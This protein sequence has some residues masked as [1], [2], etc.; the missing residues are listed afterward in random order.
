[1]EELKTGLFPCDLSGRHST[2]PPISV[3][4]TISVIVFAP[5]ANKISSNRVT[6]II[7][8]WL[9]MAI[10]DED[11]YGSLLPSN[12]RGEPAG[13][14]TISALWLDPRIGLLSGSELVIQER[15][16]IEIINMLLLTIVAT[17][18]VAKLDR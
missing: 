11:L 3:K 6:N 12:C 14:P 1:M 18:N 9:I 15:N 8:P 10:V 5:I 16:V 13:G 4:L 2:F 17:I 7:G